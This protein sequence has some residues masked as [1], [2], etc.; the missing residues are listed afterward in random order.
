[1]EIFRW[2]LCCCTCTGLFWL[3]SKSSSTDLVTFLCH[4]WA[5]LVAATS[6][7]HLSP[8]RSALWLKIVGL[9]GFVCCCLLIFIWANFGSFVCNVVLV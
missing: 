2:V 9:F 5:W 7:R 8:V 3:D 4:L 6:L 1:M